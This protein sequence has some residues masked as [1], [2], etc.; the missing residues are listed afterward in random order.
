M[1]C[2]AAMP[3]GLPKNINEHTLEMIRQKLR[4]LPEGWELS[5]EELA[6]LVGLA[7]CTVRRYLA[8]L[9]EAG[10]L[11]WRVHY[12]GIGRPVKKYQLN[13]RCREKHIS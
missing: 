11:R 8:V 6:L 9:T 5:C 13:A 10:T 2:A 3:L 1:E 7:R 12:L 4:S